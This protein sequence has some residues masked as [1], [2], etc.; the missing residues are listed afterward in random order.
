LFPESWLYILGILFILTVLFFEKGFWGLIEMLE[1]KL[2][3]WSP[4]K[5]S[6]SLKANV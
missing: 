5:G 3:G 4:A 6:E 1:A 2:T